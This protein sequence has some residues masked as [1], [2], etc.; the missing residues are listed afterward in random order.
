L[1]VWI[2]VSLLAAVTALSGPRETKDARVFYTGALLY[3]PGMYS[4]ES[5][6][7]AQP[8]QPLLPFFR[9]PFYAALLRPL[10]WG[11]FY[12]NWKLLNL[13]AA[14]AFLGLAVLEF[15]TYAVLGAMFFLPLWL[16]LYFGQDGAIMLLVLLGAIL[17]W[18]KERPFLAGLLLAMTLQKPT[19]YFLIP[20]AIVWKR[21]WRT[22]AGY[23][24]G[25][26]MAVAVSIGKFNY[27]DY[28]SLVAA[29]SARE[30]WMPT[31][32]GLLTFA[33]CAPAWLP[34]ALL[35]VL[36]YLWSLDRT[37]LETGFYGAI[38]VSLCVSRQSYGHDLAILLLP[39]LYFITRGE[40]LVRWT[41]IAMLIPLVYLLPQ[42]GEPWVIGPAVLT[43]VFAAS[44]IGC[45]V[46][47]VRRVALYAR[48]SFCTSTA[49]TPHSK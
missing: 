17:C 48:P 31:L 2:A 12:Q 44:I 38:A 34:L 36:A 7:A 4:V 8:G 27:Q 33:G 40:G 42:R 35:L 30:E 47:P 15:D 19:L 28:S 10:L 16:S 45:A 14:V 11:D 39:A 18:K 37:G 13:A 25:A 23:L 6:A 1:T 5:Q 21:E 41:A 46:F 22:F 49:P 20:L 26:A 9:A 43:I 3:G 24:A 32:R 29:F